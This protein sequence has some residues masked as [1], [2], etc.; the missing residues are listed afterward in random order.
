MESCDDDDCEIV[1]RQHFVDNDP[2]EQMAV[3]MSTN[4]STAKLD[5]PRVSHHSSPQDVSKQS[6]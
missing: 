6:L 4:D 2:P 5:N 1:E 3:A